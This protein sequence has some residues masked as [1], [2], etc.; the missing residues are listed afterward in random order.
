MIR[1]LVFVVV[2]LFLAAG[3]V[4]LVRAGVESMF[5]VSGPEGSYFLPPSG[6]VPGRTVDDTTPRRPA[7]PLSTVESSGPSDPT[8]GAVGE[9]V[10]GGRGRPGS[11]SGGR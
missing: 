1:Q 6:R 5:E 9:S 2:W 11:C 3:V 8:P 7:G 4:P 10:R